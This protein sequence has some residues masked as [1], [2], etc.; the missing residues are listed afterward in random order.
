MHLLKH[1]FNSFLLTIAV[2]SAAQAQTPSQILR[3]A[4]VMFTPPGAW[5][6]EDL[7][8][9][10]GVLMLAPS[11]EANWQANIFLELREDKE[12]RTL[13]RSLADVSGNLKSRKNQYRELSRSVKRTAR[14]VPYA[15][16]EYSQHPNSGPE[17]LE[18]EVIVPLQGTTRL[19][20]YASTAKSVSPKYL[21][22]F[23]AFLDSLAV[24]K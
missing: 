4:G 23:Q 21:P 12:N 19:F 9:L 22:V 13:E 3:D 17:L 11:V 2:I 10:N 18:W 5:A 7:A 8:K 1:F 24:A 6:V 16:L 14:G 15:L 20:V